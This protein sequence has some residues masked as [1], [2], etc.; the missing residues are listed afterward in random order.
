[1]PRQARLDAPGIL[2]HVIIKGLE[3]GEIFAE[4]TDRKYFIT[5]MGDLAL[6]LETK[7]YPWA[8]MGNHVHILLRTVSRELA[9]YS[10]IY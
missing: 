9:K 4:S 5:R 10:V 1:M 2:Q 7:V 6:E 3:G 8:L